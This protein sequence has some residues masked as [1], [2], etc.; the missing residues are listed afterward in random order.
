MQW[1]LIIKGKNKVTKTWHFDDRHSSVHCWQTKWEM[2]AGTSRWQAVSPLLRHNCRRQTSRCVI[3]MTA[4]RQNV[5]N[6][7]RD[8]HATNQKMS[9]LYHRGKFICN[10]MIN[11][12]I[13]APCQENTR[14]IGTS[15]VR[16]PK[17]KKKIKPNRG[18]TRRDKPN[19]TQPQ[20]NNENNN[21]NKK[22]TSTPQQCALY[23]S[24]TLKKYISMISFL[25][26]F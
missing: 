17:C 11:K 6:I 16:E 21:N 5:N 18:E 10:S 12:E 9:P 20:N 2:D 8:M 23:S 7:I 25:F 22:G 3:A 24:S 19:L 4:A 14:W 1:K 15:R 26:S 13:S